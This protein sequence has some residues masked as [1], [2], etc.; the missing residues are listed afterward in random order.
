MFSS[1]MIWVSDCKKATLL[2]ST[3]CWGGRHGGGTGASA[4]LQGVRWRPTVSGT[5]MDLRWVPSGNR[6]RWIQVSSSSFAGAC[7]PANLAPTQITELQKAAR[8][9]AAVLQCSLGSRTVVSG[10]PATSSRIPTQL[11][12]DI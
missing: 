11:T 10:Y 9:F 7:S 5:Q 2:V 3:S 1:L 12:H 4:G 6:S 8:L